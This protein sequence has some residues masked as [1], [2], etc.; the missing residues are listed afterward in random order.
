MYRRMVGLVA[1]VILSGWM[2]ASAWAQADFIR[3]DVNCDQVVD[4]AD[5]NLLLQHLFMGHPLPCMDAADIN[6]NGAVTIPDFNL[7]A[8]YLTGGAPPFPPFPTC[9]QD[10]TGDALTCQTCCVTQT[11]CDS[12]CQAGANFGPTGDTTL[13]AG[14]YE[15]CDFIIKPGVTVD[16]LGPCTLNI[17]RQLAI[18]EGGTLRANCT[19][20]IINIETELVPLTLAG[21]IIDTCPS[22]EMSGGTLVIRSVGSMFLGGN[23]TKRQARIEAA[24]IF[25]GDPAYQPRSTPDTARYTETGEDSTLDTPPVCNIRAASTGDMQIE[26]ELIQLSL[27]STEPLTKVL[28][29]GDGSSIQNPASPVMHTYT[30][31]GL[32]RVRYSVTD[33]QGNTSVASLYVAMPEGTIYQAHVDPFLASNLMVPLGLPRGW[34]ASTG[35][36]CDLLDW[37]FDDGTGSSSP[38]EIHTFSEAG[39]HQVSTRHETAEGTTLD[40]LAPIYVTLRNGIRVQSDPQAPNIPFPTCDAPA[41]R[42]PAFEAALTHDTVCAAC[43]LCT[44]PPESLGV[45]PAAVIVLNNARIGSKR[46]GGTLAV[47]YYDATVI[48]RDEF[49]MSGVTGQAGGPCENGGPGGGWV[50]ITTYGQIVECGGT[51]TL[52]DGGPGGDCTAVGCPKAVADGGK[53]GPSGDVVYSSPFGSVHLC[54]SIV[55]VGGDGG[56]GG[57]GEAYGAPVGACAPGCGA[58]GHGGRGGRA[59]GGFGVLSPTICFDSSYS[60]SLLSG[61]SSDGGVGGNGLAQASDGGDC[62]NCD[63]NAGP[64]GNAW[65]RGGKGG[66]SF[67]WFMFY[68]FPSDLSVL[69]GHIIISGLWNGGNAGKADAFA[70]HGGDGTIRC[71]DYEPGIDGGDGGDADAHGGQGGTGVDA[72]GLPGLGSAVCGNGGN[73]FIDG[74]PPGAAGGPGLSHDDVV[75]GVPCF[76]AWC[77]AGS[78]GA[79]CPIQGIPVVPWNPR[80]NFPPGFRFSYDDTTFNVPLYQGNST[81]A[82]VLARILSK[83]SYGQHSGGDTSQAALVFEEILRRHMRHTG[84]VFELAAMP[85]ATPAVGFYADVRSL[86][87]GGVG[88]HLEGYQGGVKVLEAISQPVCAETLLLIQLPS[89]MRG[90]QPAGLDSVVLWGDDFEFDSTYGLAV[91]VSSGDCPIALTG[92]VN[93]NGTI[94]SADIINLVNYVF[95]G[96]PPP[97]PCVAAGD[98]NCNGAVTSADIINLVNYVFKGGPPPCDGCT[99]PLAGGC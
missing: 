25:I 46:A 36:N 97:L 4:T 61:G 32:H 59:G 95:K 42:L 52:G 11:H 80:W 6:D 99:S 19:P 31:P 22:S 47:A 30:S 57:L 66:T 45:S 33:P 15:F 75:A 83:Y 44:I 54:G 76:F 68:P 88:V 40:A 16:V 96:G 67:P 14:T 21:N 92:D 48:I 49:D 74:N 93:V 71:C 41:R 78:P 17:V 91:L 2:Q 53:G 8:A 98:V 69:P 56:D 13:A 20:L 60:L 39:Y 37:D 24:D 65:A 86:S 35:D 82:Q 7:L 63:Y 87:A 9:G 84:I 51:Y 89:A 10:P 28:D 85:Q 29:F 72:N 90:G 64:G 34:L 77:S 5:Q 27:V 1:A 70:G 79:P 58:D 62:D 55:V 38:S 26:V 23:A 81:A 50:Q 94:T 18:N 73:G 43:T 12:V 3:G